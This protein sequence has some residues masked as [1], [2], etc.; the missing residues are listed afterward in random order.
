ME[1]DIYITERYGR[2]LKMRIPWLPEKI[3]GKSGGTIRATYDIMDRGPVEVAT[4][5]GLRSFSWESIFPGK[6][7]TDKSMLRGTADLVPAW[8][9]NIIEE[10]RANRTPLNLMVTG[11]PINVDVILDEYTSNPAGGFGDIEYD[12]TFVEDRD[13]VVQVTSPSAQETPAKRPENQSNATSYTVVSGDN[14]WKIAQSKLGKGSRSAE[15]YNLN[16]DIIE[17]TAKKH[18][19]KSS[20]NGWWIYP[21][22]VLK[23]PQ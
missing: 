5:S 13:I 8:Y 12:I 17:S 2:M 20:N 18:G 9:D 22:T 6:N 15:I 4:G 3:E 10:W 16:K 19:K 7:R 14:L 11:Y 21:G 23:L 1:V